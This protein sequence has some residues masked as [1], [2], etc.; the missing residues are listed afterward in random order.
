MSEDET[1]S[2]FGAKTDL[3]VPWV[4]DDDTLLHLDVPPVTQF[5]VSPP[6]T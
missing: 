5:I 6:D 2:L 1:P 4:D 3:V